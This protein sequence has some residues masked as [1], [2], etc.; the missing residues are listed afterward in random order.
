LII[1]NFNPLSLSAASVIYTFYRAHSNVS[2]SIT[3]LG[4]YGSDS[5]QSDEYEAKITE[6]KDDGDSESS[7]DLETEL[8]VS[9]WS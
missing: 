1:L 8:R 7:D 3:G 2:S 4:D 9:V 5:E 6:Q